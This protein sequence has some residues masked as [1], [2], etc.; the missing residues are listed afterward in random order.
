MNRLISIGIVP[1][2]ILSINICYADT[3]DYKIKQLTFDNTNHESISVNSYGEVV[4]TQKVNGYWQVFSLDNGQLT[5]DEW[6]HISPDINSQGEIVYIRKK[7]V[8]VPQIYS[9]L[10]GQISQ[11]SDNSEVS[12]PSIN[13]K[14][15]II[16]R[17]RDGSDYFF[18]SN[19]RGRITRI[20]SRDADIKGDGE[21][22]YIGNV[23]PYTIELF[24][25]RRGQIMSGF[26]GS[27]PKIN[28][29]G[30][31]AWEHEV[32]V[33]NKIY[34]QIFSSV[35]GNVTDF[36]EKDSV[37][38]G[39]IDDDGI[40]YFTKLHNGCYQVFS[41]IPKDMLPPDEVSAT[42]D[43]IAEAY[44]TPDKKMLADIDKLGKLERMLKAGLII[45][46]PTDG[47]TVRGIVNVSVS[48]NDEENFSHC[49]FQVD[50]RH[51]GWD[52]SPPFNFTW[53]SAY[54]DNGEHTIT[55]VGYFKNSVT[56]NEIA[57][58]TVTSD[59]EVVL[60]PSLAITS[61]LEG[62][63]VSG[64]VQIN[65]DASGGDFNYVYSCV[66]ARN[67]DWDN[68]APYQFTL[69]T[70]ALPN[71]T[72]TIKVYGWHK[73]SGQSVQDTINVHVSN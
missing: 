29:N 66:D 47:S 5:F 73:P 19:I 27:K 41:A 31:I 36:L 56:P 25:T 50:K 68:S 63:A 8:E 52:N 72:H 10:K 30:E 69:D 32:S 12:N 59:N 55:I 16:W 13:D 44:K 53:N 35:K 18:Y 24:S 65:T 42:E 21:V 3:R 62:E 40:I 34:K 7:D 54:W 11:I 60:R 17:E 71:G 1:V 46:N 37:S 38:I 6:D 45:T 67:N 48:S 2:L 15:E 64:V 14:G 51:I 20:P 28:N 4:W 22:I 61:P 57:T 9:N 43:K 26:S 58:V 33:G 23:K 70:S 39:S 49:Y